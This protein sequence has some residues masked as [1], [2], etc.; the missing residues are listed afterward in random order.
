MSRTAYILRRLSIRSGLKKWRRWQAYESVEENNYPGDA[1]CD[2]ASDRRIRCTSF[3]LYKRQHRPFEKVEKSVE[4]SLDKDNMKRQDGTA[5]KRNFGLNAADY[6]G[7]MYYSSEFSISSEEVLLIKA[8]SETQTAEISSAIEERIK[9]RM[10]DF[11]G[12]APESVQLLEDAKKSVRGKYVFLP[13]RRGAEKYLEIL[14]TVYKSGEGTGGCYLAVSHFV[15]VLPIVM[16][17]Y[18]LVPNGAKNIVLLWRVCFFT[19]GE[20]RSMSCS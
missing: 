13:L 10:N 9:T 12:I 14:T 16:A 19:H 15:Y 1:L 8:K 17:V 11:E 18:Y 20:S 2:I 7:V 6:D 3:D 5:L 4:A